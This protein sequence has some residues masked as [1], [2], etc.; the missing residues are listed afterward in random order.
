[1]DWC[2]RTACIPL[3]RLGGQF[4]A[5]EDY[6]G[7]PPIVTDCIGELSNDKCFDEDP[8]VS[9]VGLR[10]IVI[11]ESREPGDHSTRYKSLYF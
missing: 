8:Y 10:H 5:R 2:R 4:W 3:L 7:P 11:R 9:G 1:M 6:V